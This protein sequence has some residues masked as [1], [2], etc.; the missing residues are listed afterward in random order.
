ML[1]RELLLAE[2][3]GVEVL[4]YVDVPVHPDVVAGGVMLSTLHADVPLLPTRTHL[5]R[6][7]KIPIYLCPAPAAQ[8]P[9]CPLTPLSM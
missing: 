5:R 3:A 4:A 8:A 2:L 6:Y 1:V 7:N 9:S